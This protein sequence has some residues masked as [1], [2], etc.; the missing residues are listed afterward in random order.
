MFVTI[1]L[2]L[3]PISNDNLRLIQSIVN[4]VK[5]LWLKK[6]LRFKNGL[7]LFVLLFFDNNFLREFV[8]FSGILTWNVGEEGEHADHLATTG[9]I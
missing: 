3:K 1:P 2:D 8:D 9:R 5:E 7:F 6:F 4:V